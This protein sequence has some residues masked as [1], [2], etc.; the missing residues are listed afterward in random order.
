MPDDTYVPEASPTLR[1]RLEVLRRRA[2]VTTAVFL[3]VIVAAGSFILA[4]PDLYRAQATVL[5]EGAGTSVNQLGEF[6]ENRLQAIKAEAFTRGR[7]EALVSE[8]N[9]YPELQRNAP[10]EAVLRR[11]ERDIEVEVTSTIEQSGRPTTV[12]LRVSYLGLNP[13]TAAAV[14]NELASF[15]VAQNERIRSRQAERNAEVLARQV[16][17]IRSRLDTQSQQVMRYTARNSGALPQQ[18]AAN[19]A[20]LERLNM[21][22]RLNVE[23]QMRLIE[24]RQTLQSDLATLD[25]Q[26]VVNASDPL[27]RLAGMR[28]QLETLRS[29]VTESHPDVRQLVKEIEILEAQTADMTPEAG[30]PATHR[31]ALETALAETESRIETLSEQNESVR[32]EIQAH[33]RRLEQ[34]AVRGPEMDAVTRDYQVTRELY[35]TLSREFDEARLAA[36]TEDVGVAQEFRILDPAVV[37]S[38]AVGPN[39][40][41]LL[42]GAVVLALAIALVVA[43]VVDRLDGAFYSV[44]DLRAFTRVPVLATIPAIATAGDSR[45]RVARVALFACAS[46]L[47]LAVVA[48]VAFEVATGNEQMSRLFLRMG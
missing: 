48:L 19:L 12:A 16:E 30:G 43:F 41:R 11:L 26:A 44:E 27:A 14:T 40:I 33:E 18:L 38:G 31:A 3:A 13:E 22:L 36:E 17:D 7:L 37:P 42:V 39:R 29:S 20:A 21:T 8:F 46:T 28:K 35:D 25:S 5:V 24:R 10:R 1:Q 9:L 6:T 45:R 2:G 23:E 34:S 32:G 4:L 47:V 15:Y